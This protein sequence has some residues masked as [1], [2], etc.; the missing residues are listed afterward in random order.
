[1]SQVRYRNLSQLKTC[2]EAATNFLLSEDAARDI[3]NLSDNNY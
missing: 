3:F 2:L 1:L